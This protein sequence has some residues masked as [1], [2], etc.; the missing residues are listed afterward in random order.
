MHVTP[1]F[2]V[3]VAA[4]GFL[5]NSQMLFGLFVF[6][7]ASCVADIFHIYSSYDGLRKRSDDS[8]SMQHVG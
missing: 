5:S 8:V 2:V 7:T 6:E 1:P 4:T 3:R